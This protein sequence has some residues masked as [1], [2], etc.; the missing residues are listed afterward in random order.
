MFLGAQDKMG[1]PKMNFFVFCF[2]KKKFFFK[3]EQILMN[4]IL[5]ECPGQDK[6]TDA[7]YF[8]IDPLVAEISPLTKMENAA[9]A[10]TLSLF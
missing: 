5:Y 7:K 4:D 10:S 1:P 2:M 8:K 6:F 9:P 3:N